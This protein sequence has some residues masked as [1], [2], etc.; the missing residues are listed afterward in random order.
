M[1]LQYILTALFLFLLIACSEEN[2]QHESSQTSSSTSKNKISSEKLTQ[3]FIGKWHINYINVAYTS[4]KTGERKN[5]D[6]TVPQQFTDIS[7]DGTFENWIQE[8]KHQGGVW[9]VDEATSTL[10]LTES[11]QGES[12][13]TMEFR[14]KDTLLLHGLTQGFPMTLFLNRVHTIPGQ[15][16]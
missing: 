4:P 8:I 5:L 13:L 16:Q 12:P 3:H 14:H 9:R 11:D 15:P 1:K 7:K 2:H 10:Y 6:K